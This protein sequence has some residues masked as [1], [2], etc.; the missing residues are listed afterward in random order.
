VISNFIYSPKASKALNATG[1]GDLGMPT[2]MAAN[3]LICV[4]TE[5]G[6]ICVFDFK[7]NLKCICGID[8]VG[9]VVCID[10]LTA[11][12]TKHFRCERRCRDIP[13]TIP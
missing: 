13:G 12:L 7:E 4:G 9:T 11:V 6:F 2:V 1:A 3:G 10:P 5:A 8:A